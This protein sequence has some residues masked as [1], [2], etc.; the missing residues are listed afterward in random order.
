[1]SLI[2]E[3]FEHNRA[4]VARREYQSFKT[5]RFPNKR[6]V[7]VTCMD[8]RL[9][10]LLPRA[11]NLRQGDA[12]ILKTAGA[13]VAHPFGSIMKSILV[14]VYELGAVD[15]L[16]VGHHDCGLTNLNAASILQKARERGVPDHTIANLRS[17]GIDIEHW[18]RGFGSVE[19]AIRQSVAC[20]RLHPL[21]CADVSVSGMIMHPETGRLDRVE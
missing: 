2:N 3:I 7:V 13:V 17:S 16:I 4:F 12:K 14:A 9:S 11:M 1:M 19:E 10:E 18:L 5:D 15:I 21:L 8:T 6:V 20:V